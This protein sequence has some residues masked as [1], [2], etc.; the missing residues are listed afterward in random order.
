MKYIW[1]EQCQES[2]EG[3]KYALTHALVLSLPIFNERIEIICDDFLLGL[4]A[5]I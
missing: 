4:E 5:V 2:F 3:V 1:T